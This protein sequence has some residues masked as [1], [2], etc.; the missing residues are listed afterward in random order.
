M[1]RRQQEKLQQSSDGDE[2]FSKDYQPQDRLSRPHGSMSQSVESPYYVSDVEMIG[3]LVGP[4]EEGEGDDVEDC[5]YS[6]FPRNTSLQIDEEEGKEQLHRMAARVQQ[7]SDTG[8]QEQEPESV[9]ERKSDSTEKL[10]EL[11]S[12]TEAPAA[13]AAVENSS[14]GSEGSES[15]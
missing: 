6:E 1:R 4:R 5:E 3:K 12:D 14:L 11:K 10:P 2:N 15:L 13:T 8:E 7:D 9:N